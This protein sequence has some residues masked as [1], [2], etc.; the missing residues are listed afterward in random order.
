MFGL[1]AA[2]EPQW[3]GQHPSSATSPSNVLSIWNYELCEET[4]LIISSAVIPDSHHVRKRTARINHRNSTSIVR[5]DWNAPLVSHASAHTEQK[6]ASAVMTYFE[7]WVSKNERYLTICNLPLISMP[8]K[9][10][11]AAVAVSNTMFPPKPAHPVVRHAAGARSIRR[12]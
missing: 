10:W 5:K 12:N 6:L 2:T 1:S 4:V 7:E 3:L 9:Q 8:E 11:K